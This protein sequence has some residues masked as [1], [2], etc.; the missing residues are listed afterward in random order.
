[1][2]I[3]QMWEIYYERR[4]ETNPS[5]AGW[6]HPIGFNYFLSLLFCLCIESRFWRVWFACRISPFH[7]NW[8]LLS[9]CWFVIESSKLS[10][11]NQEQKSM[12][13]IIGEVTVKFSDSN[14]F[15]WCTFDLWTKENCPMRATIC[16]VWLC[17]WMQKHANS[18]RVGTFFSIWLREWVSN[19]YWKIRKK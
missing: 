11:W 16:T 15:A 1:M 3:F 13:S 8:M 6:S 12:P 2:Q 10:N 9:I 19:P 18:L 7:K 14:D 5:R 4:K 17:F